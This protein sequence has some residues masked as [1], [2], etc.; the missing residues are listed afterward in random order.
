MKKIIKVRKLVSA[1]MIGC[2]ILYTSNLA[3]VYAASTS[4][5]RAVYTIKQYKDSCKSKNSNIIGKFNYD[6]PV[7]KGDSDVV[8][9]INSTLKKRY[10]DA[11]ENKSLLWQYVKDATREMYGDYEGEFYCESGCKVTYNNNGYISF[12]FSN[13]WF[14]GGVSSNW[15]EG[16]TFDLKTGKLL[17]VSDVVAG[18]G[19][20]IKQ[21]IKNKCLESVATFSVEEYGSVKE[22]LDDMELADVQFVL[23]NGKVL[24]YITPPYSYMEEIK[25]K[26]KGNYK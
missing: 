12:L 26:L 19:A 9:K 7:L 14:A 8:K 20:K 24:V 11:L 2:I 6:L 5:K 16:L 4:S 15:T 13:Y 3:Y 25:I 10:K 1:L 17:D 22:M 18:S 23:K 21:K